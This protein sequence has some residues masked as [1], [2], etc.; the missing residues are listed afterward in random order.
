MSSLIP[1]CVSSARIAGHGPVL[2]A[3]GLFVIVAA[4]LTT[5]AGAGQAGSV[6]VEVV[7]WQH[8]ANAGE[9]RVG[10]S[11]VD[12]S[13]PAPE[14]L[15]L[16][17]GGGV[18]SS[19]RY[20]YGD[21]AIDVEWRLGAAPLTVQVRIWQHVE[22]DRDIHISARGSLGSWRTLGTVP[23][24]LDTQDGPDGCCRAGGVTIEA[25]LP[26]GATGAPLRYRFDPAEQASEPGSYVFLTAPVAREITTYEGLRHDAASVVI[27]V[28]E[29]GEWTYTFYT[30]PR[31][32][33]ITTYEG[34]RRDAAT[35][36]VNAA[37]ADGSS[38]ESLFGAVKAGHLVEWFHDHD[39]F[40]RYRVTAVAEAEAPYREFG[41]RPETYVFQGCQS[42]SLPADGTI[43]AFSAAPELPLAHLGGLSLTAPVI[44]CIIQ[45]V[46][47]GW[48]GAT[49]PVGPRLPAGPTIPEDFTTSLA[50]AREFPHWREPDL[51]EGWQFSYA[52]SGDESEV[53][54]FEAFY[55]GLRLVVSAD[56][57]NAKYSPKPATWTYTN[58]RGGQTGVRE[59][60]QIAGRPARVQRSITDTQFRVTVHVW[61]EATGVLYMLRGS[62]DQATLIAFAESMFE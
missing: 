48:T 34:L 15:P 43:A 20:R 28:D 32:S 62:P 49:Q 14:M 26:E 61:D 52:V 27:E 31:A 3:L 56:G 11:P 60:L 42:G 40:V 6:R 5:P 41:V 39:C 7:V 18:S 13:W 16:A 54:Y 53:G 37:A 8:A 47:A 12:G 21:I 4:L 24:A 36:R 23:L 25:P 57:I 59:P 55:D 29:N 50:E 45:F 30:A 22:D 33:V 17:L 58:D 2:A 51:P 1:V 19:G 10:A 38:S 44:H 46:P 35:L 9:I